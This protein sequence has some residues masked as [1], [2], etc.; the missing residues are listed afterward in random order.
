[1]QNKVGIALTHSDVIHEDAIKI[2]AKTRCTSALIWGQ[3]PARKR[4]GKIAKMR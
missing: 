2:G 3:N 4:N 1:M